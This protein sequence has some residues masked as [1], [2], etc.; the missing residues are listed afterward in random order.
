MINAYRT[1][2][3]TEKEKLNLPVKSKGRTAKEKVK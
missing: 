1:T 3:P 2:I